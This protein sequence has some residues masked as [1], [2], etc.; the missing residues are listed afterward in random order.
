MTDHDDVLV[1]DDVEGAVIDFSDDN[2]PDLCDIADELDRKAPPAQVYRLYDA[3]GDLLYVGCTGSIV[4][5]L[6]TH[7]ALKPWWSEVR[8]ITLGDPLPRGVALDAEV[9][10]IRSEHPRYNI[11]HK[12]TR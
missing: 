4:S 6:T 1:L 9:V 10:A 11:L 5:R 7:T 3:R 12:V 8:T 2:L